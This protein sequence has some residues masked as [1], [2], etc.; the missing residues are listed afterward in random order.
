MDSRKM[1]RGWFAIREDEA[2]SSGGLT[3]SATCRS[4]LSGQSAGSLVGLG[5]LDR[6]NLCLPAERHP[7]VPGGFPGPHQEYLRWVA[8]PDSKIGIEERP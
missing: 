6:A 2:C 5:V 8:N 7:A 3:P 1:P 4:A